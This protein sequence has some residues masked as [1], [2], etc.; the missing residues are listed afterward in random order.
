MAAPSTPPFVQAKLDGTKVAYVRLGR[1]G[2]RVSYPILGAMGFGSKAWTP[3]QLEEAEALPVLKAAYDAGLTTWDTANMYSNGASERLIG[4]AVRAYDLPREELVLMTKIWSPV[5][6]AEP[7]L[8]GA[9]QK[10]A[11]DRTKEF[12]NAT[13]EWRRE[14]RRCGEADRC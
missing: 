9:Q 14:G 1:S 13:G 11:L 2:L 5:A 8:H 6:E 3:W 12:V 7:G 4:A 10:E